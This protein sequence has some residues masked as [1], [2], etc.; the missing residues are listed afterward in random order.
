MARIVD[1]QFDLG[2]CPASPFPALRPR[3]VRPDAATR[4]ARGG[5][6]LGA[7]LRPLSSTEIANAAGSADRKSFAVQ[8]GNY[9]NEEWENRC[10]MG[11]ASLAATGLRRLLGEVP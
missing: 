3:Q 7:G 11:S 2:H 4:L 5:G 9:P 10:R 6:V 1:G 8:L